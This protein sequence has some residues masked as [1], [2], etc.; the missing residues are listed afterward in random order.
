MLSSF[1]AISRRSTS[2]I[3]LSRKYLNSVS[4]VANWI[5]VGMFINLML[6]LCYRWQTL[7]IPFVRSLPKI[8]ISL[9]KTLPTQFQFDSSLFKLMF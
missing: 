5:I 6:T 4:K 9:C 7:S 2:E 3:I 8:T 1:N